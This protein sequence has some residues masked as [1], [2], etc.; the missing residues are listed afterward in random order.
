MSG[1]AEDLKREQ[2][3][4]GRQLVVREAIS[5]LTERDPEATQMLRVLGPEYLDR[6]IFV[7]GHSG[8]IRDVRPG[9]VPAA[10]LNQPQGLAPHHP[11]T[12]V[13]IEADES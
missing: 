2:E 8:K 5:L 1:P 7:H 11:L 3:R 4:L 9:V 13:R 12:Y 10:E 6:P